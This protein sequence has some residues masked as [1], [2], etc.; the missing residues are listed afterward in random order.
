MTQGALLVAVAAW[1]LAEA[2]DVK[3]REAGVQQDPIIGP[4]E[5]EVVDAD[6]H[7]GKLQAGIPDRI[8][9]R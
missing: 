3:E 1:A 5:Q 9:P 4:E 2:P 7:A 6:L 8:R